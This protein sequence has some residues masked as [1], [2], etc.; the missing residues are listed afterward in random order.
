MKAIGLHERVSRGFGGYI[1]YCGEYNSD[2]HGLNGFIGVY[3]QCARA[4]RSGLRQGQGLRLPTNEEPTS[5]RMMI[6]V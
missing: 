6:R 5:Q 2:L 1:S 4:L 3:L